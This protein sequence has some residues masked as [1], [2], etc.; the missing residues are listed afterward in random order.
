MDVDRQ[1]GYRYYEHA[2]SIEAGSILW[3]EYMRLAAG[4]IGHAASRNP[5][6]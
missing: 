5:P 6:T 2:K 3:F 1:L 4:L